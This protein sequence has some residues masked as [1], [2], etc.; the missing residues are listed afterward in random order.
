M[1]GLFGRRSHLTDAD[2]ARLR[3]AEDV[4]AEFEATLDSAMN[5]AQQWRADGQDDE[6]LFRLAAHRGNWKVQIRK[7]MKAA[8][9]AFEDGE[10]EQAEEYLTRAVTKARQGTD[11]LDG[12]VA[13]LLDEEV[14][15]P[16]GS[17]EAAAWIPIGDPRLRMLREIPVGSCLNENIGADGRGHGFVIAPCSEPHALELFGRGDVDARMSKYPNANSLAAEGDRICRPL[18]EEYVGLLYNQSGY[19]FWAY[20]P[21]PEDWP[22]DRTIQC[23]LGNSERSAHDNGSAKGSRR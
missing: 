3:E 5:I 21:E 16:P 4:V 17:A 22:D 23:T 6:T 9:K 19:T 1:R 7:N 11:D 12:R 8:K 18:F 20:Y 10:R 14:R 13:E 15:P 2:K